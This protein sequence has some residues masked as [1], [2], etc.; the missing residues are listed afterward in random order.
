ML[1][2]GCAWPVSSMSSIDTRETYLALG[3]HKFQCGRVDAIS[4]A[5]RLRTVVEY[6]AQVPPATGAFDF[7]SFHTEGG[8]VMH[9][10]HVL[11]NRLEETRP[12]GM[13][14]EFRIGAEQF[15]PAASAIVIARFVVV[16]I[17]ARIGL[18]GSRLTKD[19]V[20]VGRQEFLPLCIRLRY[21]LD[22]RFVGCGLCDDDSGDCHQGKDGPEDC[23]D[24]SHVVS[25]L[26]TSAID[27]V[28]L[29][30]SL[31]LQKFNDIL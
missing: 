6:V 29:P 14:I 28:T 1:G 12:S 16:P 15:Q 30:M 4:K 5:G 10:D 20:L 27:R 9:F 19:R 3:F 25:H 17:C 18:L 7:G 31:I 8:V 21:L 24:D 2:K 23:V 22:W 11:G 26:V 13:R